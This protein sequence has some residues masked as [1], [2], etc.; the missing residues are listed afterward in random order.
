M[1]AKKHAATTVEPKSLL[2]VAIGGACGAVAR[3]AIS[4]WIPSEFPWGT[5]LVN[6][7]GSFLLGVLVS[8]GIAN[9]HVTPEMLLLIGTGALGAFTTMS[10]FSLDLIQLVDAGERMP[11]VSYMLAN[12]IL[13]PLSAFI[14]WRYIPILL[15]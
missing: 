12:F 7:L 2:L 1:K 10:T 15:G 4:E 9:E 6:I 5:L 14:G 13:C 11:A 8:A 3:Y